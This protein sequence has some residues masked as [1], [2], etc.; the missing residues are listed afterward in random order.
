MWLTDPRLGAVT[1]EFTL[2]PDILVAPAFH[3]G[4]KRTRVVLPPGR[5]VHLWTGRT[6]TGRR[7]V[8]VSSPL[9]RPAVFVRPGPLR[10]LIIK[11]AEG[12]S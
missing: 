11:A 2:G 10:R 3:P 1:A 4:R 9:G 12:T 5:W 7:R 8:T 6:Y